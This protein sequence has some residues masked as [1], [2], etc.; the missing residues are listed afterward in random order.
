MSSTLPPLVLRFS[1]WLSKR[2]ITLRISDFIFYS[3]EV[4][5]SVDG[6]GTMLQDRRS[7]V[8]FTV[9]SLDF[10]IGLSQ[11]HYGPGV[12]SASNRNEYQE[13][14]WGVKGGRRVRLTTLPP[15]VSRLSREYVG[16]S[17]S[18][19]F[20]GRHGLLPG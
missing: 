5:G 4:R 17:T 15:S 11:P 2:Y 20:M 9:R 10:S 18:H 14:S 1:R 12:D 3:Q 6:W 19:N 16:A 7:R 13:S 8:R